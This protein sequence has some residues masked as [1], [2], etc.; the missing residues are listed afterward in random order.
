[1]QLNWASKLGYKPLCTCSFAVNLGESYGKR[2]DGKLYG[3]PGQ[4]PKGGHQAPCE[5][6]VLTKALAAS[7]KRL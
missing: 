3:G 4:K 1:M 7:K 5:H 2:S 6:D